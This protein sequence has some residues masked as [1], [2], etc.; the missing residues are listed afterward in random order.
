MYN[1]K[2]K[3]LIIT[4]I[5]GLLVSSIMPGGVSL[6][7]KKTDTYSPEDDF[8]AIW[9]RQDAQ[10]FNLTK[11]NTAPEIEKD[12]DLVEEDLWVWDTWPLQEKDGSVATINGYKVAFALTAPRDVGWTER[13]NI[14][15]IGVFYSKNGQDWTYSGIA[16]DMDK[17]LGSRQWAGSAII[18]EKDRVHLFYTASGRKGEEELTFEQRLAKTTFDIKAKKDGIELL[19]HGEHSILAEADGEYY[20]T[21]DQKEGDIIYSF[22]DPWYFKDP[23]TGE[24]YI[25]FEGNSAGYDKTLKPEN[26]GDK[27]F[28]EN[29]EVPEDA[30]YYNGN[31]G[32]AKAQNEELTEF[33]LLPPL[34]EAD[35]VNQQLER[36]HIVIKGNRYYLFFISHKFTFASGL[37]GPDGL[38]GFVG[39]SLRSDYKPLNENGLVV[40]NP[41]SDPF[42]AYSW[43]VLPNS[44]VISFINEVNSNGEVISGGT[45]A[46]TLKITLKGDRTKV[47][48][49][50]QHGKITPG[51]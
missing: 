34:V 26:I 1:K 12:F 17:V 2:K 10:D 9:S 11:N 43:Y 14:A 40:A 48:T 8:T 39:D 18:D 13:H 50:L 46:P 30:K 42:Q 21:Q 22:R 35:G 7:T 33:E 19:N 20:Q 29:H 49:E 44:Q 45:F 51:S 16:Y 31:I 32:I 23:K 3:I 6:A 28:R 38:Y 15:R 5:I 25:L 37:E 4:V 24:E 41:E 47:N 36:P 27:E